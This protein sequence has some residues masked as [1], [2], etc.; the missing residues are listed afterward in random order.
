MYNVQCTSSLYVCDFRGEKRD[1]DFQ[2]LSHISEKPSEVSVDVNHASALSYNRNV[3]GFDNPGYESQSVASDSCGVR[4]SVISPARRSSVIREP[5]SQESGL[6]Q[7]QRVSVISPPPNKVGRHE[8][9]NL[10]DVIRSIIREGNISAGIMQCQPNSV[11]MI[12]F[13]K[14]INFYNAHFQ[15]QGPFQVWSGF[16]T[17]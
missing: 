15:E 13:Y 8:D 9:S 7:G 16:G 1:K 12:I 10:C 2:H 6:G 5:G 11:I 3:Q 4:E 14:C 17:V